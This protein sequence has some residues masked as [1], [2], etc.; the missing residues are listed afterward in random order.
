MEWLLVPSQ[1]QGQLEGQVEEEG[2]GVCC[3]VPAMLSRSGTA[4]GGSGNIT[5]TNRHAGAAVRMFIYVT[6]PH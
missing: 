4:G 1:G 2:A 6:E 3:T 5:H